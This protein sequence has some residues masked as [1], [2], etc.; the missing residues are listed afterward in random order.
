MHVIVRQC[1]AEAISPQTPQTPATSL[2]VGGQGLMP[3]ATNMVGMPVGTLSTT[4]LAELS[5]TLQ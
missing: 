1:R 3:V 5:S 2:V 4:G